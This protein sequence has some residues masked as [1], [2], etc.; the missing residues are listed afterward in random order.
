M[1]TKND[2]LKIL[3][4]N[5]LIGDGAM[6]TVLQGLGISASPEVFISKDKNSFKILP[7]IH[8]DY[9][10]SGSNII[11]ASTFGANPVKL[12]T[13]RLKSEIKNINEKAVF[14]AKLAADN[15]KNSVDFKKNPKPVF[16]AGNIGPTGKLLKPF[17]DLTYED[18]VDAFLQQADILLKT[19]MVDLILIETMI[20]IN[21]ALAAIEAVKK[22]S[23]DIPIICT[24]TFNE[25]GVTIMGNKAEEAVNVLTDAGCTVVGANCSVGSDKMLAV[26]RKMRNANE[27]ARLIF[28]PNAGLPEMAGGKTVYSE[29]PEIMAENMKKYLDFR[30]SILGACCGSTP[31]HIK[32][33]AGLIIT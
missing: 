6:G 31:K 20:D 4:N 10:K 13:N 3:G 2:F 27:H 17:G 22:T 30:P 29:T 5:I 19:Q 15:Y 26:V 1:I 28:Q 23:M 7:E 14:C 25:T 9:L 11:Q 33:I 18:A 24:L 21:E 12:D 8:L 16:I 32:K